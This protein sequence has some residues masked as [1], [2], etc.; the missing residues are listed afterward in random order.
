[1]FPHDRIETKMLMPLH[2]VHE[3]GQRRLEPFTADA[4]RCLPDHDDRFA[5]GLVVDA[6][7][8]TCLPSVLA[9]P[10]SS[11]MPCLRWWPVAAVN[12]SRILP[13][14]F[15]DACWYRSLIVAT[16]SCFAI[17]LMLPPTWLPP[18]FSITI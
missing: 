18:E 8:T 12:S 5:Y 7:T 10:L 1:M 17:L 13:L 3:V 6:P 14:S 9:V 4:V 2:G 11:L 16:S 15:L